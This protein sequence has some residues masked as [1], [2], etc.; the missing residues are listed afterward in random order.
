[1]EEL[2]ACFEGQECISE[3]EENFK[4][5]KKANIKAP[6]AHFHKFVEPRVKAVFSRDASLV[7]EL[8]EVLPGV[9]AVWKEADEETQDTMWEYIQSMTMVSIGLS[10]MPDKVLEEFGRRCENMSALGKGDD[11]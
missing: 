6:A 7:G 2:A 4:L 5:A 10:S 9:A 11:V 3:I 8:D 1:M